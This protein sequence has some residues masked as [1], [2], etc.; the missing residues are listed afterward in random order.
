MLLFQLQLTHF[1]LFLTLLTYSQAIGLHLAL[2]AFDLSTTVTYFRREQNTR[3]VKNGGLRSSQHG[4]N[5]CR[6]LLNQG[7][8]TSF[9]YRGFV[10][11]DPS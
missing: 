5:K 10:L 3:I 9:E 6:I 2:I 8:Y 11:M 7:I 1:G 4:A